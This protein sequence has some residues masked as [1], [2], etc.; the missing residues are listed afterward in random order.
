MN[1]SLVRAVG[2]AHKEG[3]KQDVQDLAELLLDQALILDG[4]LPADPATFAKRLNDLVLRGL[5]GE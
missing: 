5:R 4:E 1:H 3:R 2:R